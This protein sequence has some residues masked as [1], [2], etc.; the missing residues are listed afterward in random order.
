MPF[1]LYLFNIPQCR[2]RGRTPPGSL[3]FEHDDKRLENEQEEKYHGQSSDIVPVLNLGVLGTPK[4]SGDHSN[5]S[6]P[7]V[8]THYHDD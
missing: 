6:S 8:H 2:F 7:M 1:A 3:N 4:I 5:D